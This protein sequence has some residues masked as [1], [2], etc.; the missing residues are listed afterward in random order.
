MVG[1][2]TEP[3][4][5]VCIWRRNGGGRKGEPGGRVTEARGASGIPLLAI[6]DEVVA[7]SKALVA[8]GA[9]PTKAIGDS[10]HI[11]VAAV[12]AADYLLTWNCRQIDNAEIKPVVRS[13]CAA[14]GYAS[15]EICTPQELMGADDNE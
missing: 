1:Y 13:V 7:S 9:L 11:A 3:V 15:P 2:P 6:T 4:F 10:L 5:A 8:R 14:Q 12:H